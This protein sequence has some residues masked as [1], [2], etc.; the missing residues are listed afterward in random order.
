MIN[1]DLIKLYSLVMQMPMGVLIM[2]GPDMQIKMANAVY[3]ELVDRKEEE[4]VGKKLLEALPELA[5]QGIQELLE[6]VL[7]TGIAYQG[8]EFKV[9]LKRHGRIE[10]AYFSF[11]YHPLLEADGRV[12]GVAVVAAE[13]T[14]I[15]KSKKSL[16]ET[17]IKFRNLVMQ[18]R[19]AMGILRGA[20]MVIEL[21]NDALLKIWKRSM[22]EV[23]GRKL[24]DVFPELHDQKFSRILRQVYQ[25]GVAY[26]EKESLALADTGEGMIK[27]YVDLVYAPLAEPDG[28][29]GGI[30]VNGVDVTQQVADREKIKEEE[31]RSRL[32]IDAANQGTFEWNLKTG[33]F[34]FSDRLA[35]I[36][37]Y[38]PSPVVTHKHLIERFHPE[39]KPIRDK[40]NEDALHTGALKY[41]LRVI[42][43]DGSL[44][45]LQI[46][47]KISYNEQKEP[48]Q[49]Y[50]IGLDITDRMLAVQ[51]I[52]KNEERFRL[53]ADF[54]PQQ[55]WTGDDKGNLNYF[56]KAVYDYSGMTLDEI[57]NQGWISIV[58]PDDR[59]ENIRQ[60]AHAV[61]TGQ[62]FIFEHRFRKYDGEYRWQLS[63]ALPHR[64]AQGQIQMWIGTSTDIH[65]RKTLS[66][67]LEKHVEMRTG[68]LKQAN[69][70]LIRT[71]LELEQFA[72]VASHD[73]QEPLRKIRTFTTML[74]EKQADDPNREEYLDK[75][76]LSAERMSL[77]IR[78]VLDYSRIVKTDDMFVAIDLNEIFA[79]V[80]ADYELLIEQKNATVTSARLPV[81]HGIPLQFSQLF[82][83]LI[84]NALKFSD[85]NPLIEVS[86]AMAGAAEA[87]AMGELNPSAQYLKLIFRDNGIG[88][89]QQYADKIFTIFQRLNDRNKYAGTGIGLAMCKKI[90]ENHHGF[91]TAQSE[92][93]RGATFTVYLLV[94]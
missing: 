11:V 23:T 89:E 56:N 3:Q 69:E 83:N 61:T 87:R 91:I 8:N 20:D 16:A 5:G 4:L 27:N 72:F 31:T 26:E 42:W 62:N 68:E 58:H 48:V 33:D 45:W 53:L 85:T 36:F 37:G 9:G 93:G 43:P 59:E 66:D 25:T 35:E 47:G 65:D 51:E 94:V 75:I 67:E 50:G 13:V 71:N 29:I 17:E 90:V 76:H 10:E 54:M 70:D 34:I 7:H 19:I 30:M 49:M 32:A 92:P 41:E 57:V 24:I 78:D 40:A 74:Q 81:V 38:T 15:V 55:I 14:N 84:G 28:R 52:E 21:A 88:F 22:D 79:N 73:L 12:S 6:S 80:V 82:S 46:K 2:E 63:R 77:L 39:D 86:S 64:D 60:W 44:H 1:G 18:S